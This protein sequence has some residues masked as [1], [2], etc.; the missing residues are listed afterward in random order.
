M[1]AAPPN[2]LSAMQY[3]MYSVMAR[4]QFPQYG[5]IA[6]P[7]PSETGA[8]AG[9][10]VVLTSATAPAFA[11]TSGSVAHGPVLP[12]LAPAPP[13]LEPALGNGW[14]AAAAAAPAPAG[15]KSGDGN[16]RR[17]DE[18]GEAA[19]AAT[20]W[21]PL[22]LPLSPSPPC[23][24]TPA[25]KTTAWSRGEG[26]GGAAAEAGAGAGSA[27]PY[28]NVKRVQGD[29]GS[30]HAS[31]LSEAERGAKRRPRH[32]R[33]ATVPVTGVSLYKCH[34]CSYIGDSGGLS[35][36]ER[37]H[38]GE[39]PFQ[40][41]HPGCTY[42]SARSDDV[43]KHFRCVSQ[44]RLLLSWHGASAATALSVIDECVCRCGGGGVCPSRRRRVG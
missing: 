38:T 29:S 36:H 16:K 35:R 7:G 32:T 3:H 43:V 10:G 42:A 26:T 24:T 17:R 27:R 28:V 18:G 23:P 4:Q 44:R 13:P 15:G 1:F 2:P 19:L 25:L 37:T 41:V 31:A 9:S 40:C 22:P 5:Y 11:L 12:T 33:V 34:Y 8:C 20:R 39:R 14:T 6:M 30:G 21:L